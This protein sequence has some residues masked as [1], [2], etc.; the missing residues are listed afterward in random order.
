MRLI[1]AVA[2]VIESSKFGSATDVR[3]PLTSPSLSWCP[4]WKMYFGEFSH[5]KLLLLTSWVSTPHPIKCLFWI[6][7]D[8]EHA[9]KKLNLERV[10]YLNLNNSNIFIFASKLAFCSWHG[11]TFIID[12]DFIIILKRNID[13]NSLVHVYPTVLYQSTSQ[14]ILV[15]YLLYAKY[16]YFFEDNTK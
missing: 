15:R 7:L 12:N 3:N 14:R 4:H 9:E 6:V 8:S 13:A 16:C 11:I 2:L 1:V 10:N 5:F